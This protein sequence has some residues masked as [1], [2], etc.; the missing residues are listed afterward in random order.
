MK[1]R[2]AAELQKDSIVD[3]EGIRAVLWTQ[4]CAHNCPGCHNPMTHSFE[5]GALIDIEEVYSWIDKLEGHDGIT[6]SGG[7]PM[8][9][10][11]PC[12]KISQYAHDKGLN[13]WC[14]TG[15]T[16]EELLKLSNKNKNI[17]E[18]LKNIDVLIDGPFILKEKSLDI[19]FR[20]SRN[21]RVI[22]VK[23]SL[24]GNKTEIL[25]GYNEDTKK[26]EQKVHV[27]I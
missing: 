27:F 14:Y 26:K 18:F 7:D 13:V 24:A 5:A 16:F 20:G 19:K 21:Q 3:G 23:R 2:L 10:P 6:L 17:M 15:F 8:Y 11:I 12:T 25:K 22:D 9:Q 4:G 1:I